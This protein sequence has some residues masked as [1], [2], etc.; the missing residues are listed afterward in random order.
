[1]AAA[2]AEV[3]RVLDRP[4]TQ[5]VTTL[6]ESRTAVL[7]G[8]ITDLVAER[9]ELRDPRLQA[10]V[11]DDLARHGSLVVSLEEYLDRFGDVRSSAAALHVH[12][13]TLRYRIRRAERVLGMRLDDPEDRLLL[14]LQLRRWRRHG[15]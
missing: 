11:D 4:G 9:D 7:L 2:R 6:A 15:P 5:H 3:D 1:M 8:E 14:Q 10:L 12:P 13:N